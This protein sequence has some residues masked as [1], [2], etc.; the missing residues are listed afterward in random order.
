MRLPS[1]HAAV[2]LAVTAALQ[3]CGGS[4][5]TD[6]DDPTATVRVTRDFGRDLL[7]SEERAPLGDRATVL[8]LL[9]DHADVETS[10][11][12]STIE[13][14]DGARRSKDGDSETT[15][16]LIVNG[17]E[18]DVTP[19]EYRV[20]PGDMVQLDLRDWYVTLDVRATVGAFPE[21]FTR[22][23]FGGRFPTTLECAQ[24]RSTAC[25]LV[26]RALERAGVAV[27]GSPPPGRRPPDGEVQRARVLVGPWKHWRDRPRPG[28][29]DR[30][31][32]YSGVFAKFTRLA[33]GIRLLDWDARTV[34]AVGAGSG[35]VAA[36]R[37]TEADFLWLVTGVDE[38]GVE[39]AARALSS[40]DLRGAFALVVTRN[41]P[42]KVPLPLADPTGRRDR[43]GG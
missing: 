11:R 20:R 10:N 36:Q 6:R 37:P 16:A 12:G 18:A 9:R 39:R 41:G 29:V 4:Q 38:E 26:R 13:A 7:L 3:G 28:R 21:T 25:R 27:D 22:G 31:A 40:S 24:A 23:S 42:T 8:R 15:W 43:E 35:L 32:R 1:I 5:A 19:D 33:D 17:I 30:G 14:I 2:L 34:R